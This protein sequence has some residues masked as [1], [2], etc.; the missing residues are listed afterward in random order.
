M[1]KLIKQI[2]L[3]GALLKDL[4]LVLNKDNRDTIVSD[5][6]F[7]LLPDSFNKECSKL[8]ALI[9]E[10][11]EGLNK[12]LFSSKISVSFDRHGFDEQGFY[13][14]YLSIKR[15][16]IKG[17]TRITLFSGECLEININSFFRDSVQLYLG[18]CAFI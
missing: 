18:T 1:N 4:S 12:S 17:R 9:K 16:I 10:N 14:A 13:S 8:D 3:V 15:G 7:S 2:N 6:L 11:R 5:V